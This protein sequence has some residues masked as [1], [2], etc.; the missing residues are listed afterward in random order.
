[1]KKREIRQ[2]GLE[3]VVTINMNVFEGGN[4]K[5]SQACSVINESWGHPS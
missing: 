1:M 4:K 5:Q 3:I 2:G